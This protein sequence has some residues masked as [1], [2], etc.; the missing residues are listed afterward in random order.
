MKEWVQE[1]RRRIAALVSPDDVAKYDDGALDKMLP[2]VK[3]V[4]PR[5]WDALRN[6]PFQMLG[7]EFIARQRNVL[8]ADQ[9]GMGKTIQTLSAIIENDVNGMIFAIAPRTA[10]N[11]TWS[12]EIRRWI[13]PD[14]VI[15]TINGSRSPMSEPR[16]Y[17]RQFPAPQREFV[18]GASWGRTTPGPR[19]SW[20][21]MIG[22]STTITATRSFA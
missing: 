1:E 22:S 16:C 7:A 12:A 20:I 5:M 19:P 11:V 3:A 9:P 4:R 2:I 10:A 18:C 6:R 8:M 21:R 14:E 17:A 15:Y 13:G